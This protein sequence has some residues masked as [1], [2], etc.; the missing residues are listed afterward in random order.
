[1]RG[2]QVWQTDGRTY[3]YSDSTTC[4]A[5]KTKAQLPQRKRASAIMHAVQDRSLLTIDNP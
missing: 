5:Q 4:A 3:M 2:S 1:M